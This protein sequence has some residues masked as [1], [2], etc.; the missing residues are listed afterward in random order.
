MEA[1][2]RAAARMLP[3][4]LSLGAETSIS[5]EEL[6]M[7]AVALRE[8]LEALRNDIETLETLIAKYPFRKIDQRLRL[9]EL[10]IL[11]RTVVKNLEE[12]VVMFDGDGLP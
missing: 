7:V 5:N 1:D 12:A 3:W 6:D 8:Q 4:S 11:Y 10:Q 9:R 2:V